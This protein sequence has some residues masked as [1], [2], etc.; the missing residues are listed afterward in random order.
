M[1]VRIIVLNIQMQDYDIFSFL[2]DIAALY[3][4]AINIMLC[5]AFYGFKV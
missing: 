2:D 3:G 4:T 1:G 5:F